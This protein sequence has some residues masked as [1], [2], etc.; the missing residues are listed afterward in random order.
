MRDG[1]SVQDH[2]LT[3][4]KDMEELEKLGV[5]LDLDLQNDIILQSLTDA[6]GQFIMNYHMHKL[7]NSL[8]E[9][10]NMLV[11]AEL[12]MKGSK[13]SVLAMERTS[14][15]RKSYG[16]K[17]K[18]VEKQKVEG[19][20]KKKAEPKKKVDVKG[21]CFHCNSDGHWKRNCPTYLATLKNKKEGPSG[22]MLVIESNLTVSSAS[23]W[24]LDSGSSAHLC[25][26][27]QGLEDSRRLRDG[28]M[29]LRIGNGARVA[30]VA[31]GTYPLRLPSGLDL[32][33]KDYYYVPAASRN[34][35]SVSC[36]AQE[37][38][39]ITFFKDH[40]NIL[41][42][43]NK[44]VNGFLINGLYQLHIDVSVLTIEQNVN[45]KRPRDSPN[46]RYLW[47]LRL[48][49]IAEDRINKLE[50]NGL[51]SPLTF[52]SYP[53]CESCLQGKMTKLPF[54][55]HGERATDLLALVH[56]DVCGPFDVPARGNFVYFITFTDDLS[57]YGYVYLMRHKSEAFEKFKEFRHEV[58]KQTGKPIKVLRS[59][60]GGEYLSRE[61]LDY[62]KENGIVSQ[63]TPPG[64]PQLNGVSERRNRT[65]LDMV[66]SMMSFTDLPDF[67]WGHSLLTSI[68]LLNRVPSKTV[69]TTPYEI[70]HGK[71]P[72]LSHLRIWG[73]PAHVK[74][75]QADKLEF[76][77]FRARFIGY[78]KESLGYYFYI[79]EDHNVIVSRHA[80]FLEK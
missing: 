4:I 53:T 9:L 56:T 57:R 59:D 22:G 71:K 1:Q 5:K 16:K 12:S 39:V 62:L 74:R 8:A 44:I 78:P 67:L 79:P 30:A 55:G 43:R 27:M 42:E 38:Y 40:C 35:I 11:T 73:C 36:L 25:T 15:K 28:D 33:L 49:H 72:S 69:P 24:V 7:Q 47:H 3:M 64:T 26:S 58:E 63:W 75:Q 41:Y 17:K 18:S 77:S 13:G 29:I 50:K 54:V 34:L 51:L 6:Y 10:M 66:R 2:C 21:K 14:S 19:S 48:G 65:L 31:M 68:Y 32:V 45:A 46:D 80:I 23:S 61:F 52:E 70:W 76:R 20:K 60:R 37:G